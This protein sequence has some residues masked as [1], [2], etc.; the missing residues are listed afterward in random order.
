MSEYKTAFITG[1]NGFVGSY[2]LKHL[3][4]NYPDMSIMVGG[5]NA[6]RTT[7]T[8]NQVQ[9]VSLD[10]TTSIA[11]QA[12][13]DIVF[14]IAGE[15]SNESKMWDVNLQG[16]RKLLNWS[17]LNGVKRFVYLSSVG[18]YGA[19]KNEGNI[20]EESIKTPQNTYEKSKS[21]AED[22]VKDYCKKNDMGYTILQPSNVIGIAAN[23]YP[24]LSMM[25]MVKKGL[26]TYFDDGSACFNY[27]AVQ[28]VADGLIAAASDQAIN[29]TF[30]L[31]SPLQMKTI[32]DL[33]AHTLGVAPPRHTLPNAIGFIASEMAT[34]LSLLTGK[35]LPFNRGRF[36]EL[37]NKTH[38]DGSAIFKTT[39]FNY[40]L[41][42]ETA[43][44][45]LVNH[46]IKK[47]LL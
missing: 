32:V 44:Q 4:S 8:P 1:A 23:A 21:A 16:T 24:L 26:F 13:P 6:L 39:N 9:Y 2:F 31:N 18:V 43:I 28:D 35:S 29:R 17:A 36:N 19:Q 3:T 33:I 12:K 22:L 27:V 10:L 11:I 20:T 42:I 30:I 47:G 46:Y 41:G 5:R 45:Q 14:H 15:K 34:S 7:T 40:P 25:R 38:Y 37:T